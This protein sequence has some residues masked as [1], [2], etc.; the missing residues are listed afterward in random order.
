MYLDPGVI[1]TGGCRYSNMVEVFNPQTKQ[2]CRIPDLPGTKIWSHSQCGR[3]LCGGG[4]WYS[5]TQRSCKMLNPLTGIF[6]RTSVRLREKRDGHLCWDVEG[7]TGPI[8]LM[9]GTSTE[10][11]SPDGSS[12]SASFNLQYKTR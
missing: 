1:I 7:E 4:G 6:T 8:L 11:V 3:L 5:S 9:G 2:T 12:S 10:L